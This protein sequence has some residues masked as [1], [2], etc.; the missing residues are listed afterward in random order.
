[1][2]GR[3]PLPLVLGVL[4]V[5]AVLGPAL[6]RLH[7]HFLGIAEVD[8]FGTQ[9]FYW[10]TER[11]LLEG[12]SLLHTDLFYHPFGKDVLAHTGANVLDAI[13]AMPLR[14]L[15]GPVLGYNLF[16]ILGLAW[17]GWAFSRL[18]RHFVQD[19]SSVAVASLLFA[20]SPFVLYEAAEGRPTQAILGLIPLFLLQA[21]RA[22]SERGWRA[23][24]LAGVLLAVLGYQYWY[25]AIFGGLVCAGLGAWR[26]L[27]PPAEAGSRGAILGR[28]LTMAGVAIALAAPVA[29]PMLLRTE[30]D[31][32]TVPGLLDVGAWSMSGVGPVTV[33]GHRIAL[34]SWQPLLAKASYF[35]QEADGSQSLVGHQHSPSLLLGLLLL[36]WL[37]WPGKLDRGGLLCALAPALLI[38][39][40]PMIAIGTTAVPSPLYILLA[41]SLGFMQ[42]LW[43]PARAFAFVDVLMF[44]MAAVLLE[45]TA[46]WGP[47]R[48]GALLTGAT[49]LMAGSLLRAGLLPFPTW[50]ASIPAGYRCL[51]GG[52]E[53]SLI[54]LPYGWTQAHLYYQSAHG[55]PILGGMLE[56]NPVFIPEEARAFLDDSPFVSTL[57]RAAQSGAA[58]PP[59]A[60]EQGREETLDLSY[61]WVLLQRDAYFTV[62][63]HQAD[64]EVRRLMRAQ[65]TRLRKVERN[66]E[67]LLGSPL[68][69]DG[70]TLI[71]PVDPSDPVAVPCAPA[72][73]DGTWSTDP[74]HRAP[75]PVS[76][77]SS[78]RTL[79]IVYLR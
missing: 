65:Q 48:H 78:V 60:F 46:R 2:R 62:N 47:W 25:Y 5:G 35:M 11:G 31:A 32:A 66:L 4:L 61:R 74:E 59:G 75:R 13:L 77:T 17:S 52:P 69:S 57:I 12:E 9:W 10:F 68:Y 55:R 1:M 8:H 30:L 24:L 50:D 34:L 58:E 33:E 45:R 21:W 28:Y 26:I 44:L 73:R 67:Q 72:L 41:K 70:R 19:R 39:V 54:E 14:L 49:A 6:P 22:G 71:Y 29:G 7:R 20:L 64:E 43:W 16:V 37:R 56:R 18:A 23:P 3:P 38:S 79:P 40:G 51:E 36:A 63:D 53:G 15:L 27:R 42:R 76:A